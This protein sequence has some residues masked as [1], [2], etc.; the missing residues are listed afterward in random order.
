M[1]VPPECV[2]L[3]VKVPKTKKIFEVTVGLRKGYDLSVNYL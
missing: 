2:N 1:K 3:N